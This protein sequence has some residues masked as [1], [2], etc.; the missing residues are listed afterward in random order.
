LNAYRFSLEWSRIEPEPGQFSIAMLDHYKA[1]IDGCR[2]RHLTPV[3]TFSHWTV[4]IWFAAQGGWTHPDAPDLF[5]RFCEK[6]ARHLAKGI[7]YGVTLNEPNG[8][9][10]GRKLAPPIAMVAQRAMLEA[11]ARRVGS[12]TFVG[13]PTF[14]YAPAMQAGLLKGHRAAF[15]AIKSVRSDLPLGFSIAI[16]DDEVKGPDSLRDSMR[17]EFYG[18]WLETAKQDDF[19]GIQNYQRNIWDAK[20]LVAPAADASLNSDGFEI[21]PTSLA[22]AAIYAHQVTGRP[23]M[24]TEHGVVSADDKLRAALIPAAL[25][26]LKSAMDK[27]VPVMGYMH[28]SLMDNFE[29]VSGYKSRYGLASVDRTTFARTL[30]PSAAILGKIAR[31]NKL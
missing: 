1:V 3:V 18:A 2:A 16:A 26:A 14:E 24:V 19:L 8:L 23:I 28:W 27:G 13:G 15:S 7:G 12:A 6:A 20:G 21:V 30:K 31:T 9:L 11:A 29:W 10:I 5:A 22:G 4:P 25:A 17:Q